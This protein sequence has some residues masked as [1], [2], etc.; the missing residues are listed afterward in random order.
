[1]NVELE[2]IVRE[3]QLLSKRFES[4]RQEL[5][6]RWRELSMERSSQAR[7]WDLT[8]PHPDELEAGFLAQRKTIQLIM[9]E[10]TDWTVRFNLAGRPLM[11][12]LTPHSE[13]DTETKVSDVE[14]VR[15]LYQHFEAELPLL[16]RIVGRLESAVAVLGSFNS[17][18]DSR[19]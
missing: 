11:D 3:T 13:S 5:T 9:E 18:P 16:E 17:A 10:F 2:E 1:V 6:Q 7:S 15:E 8:R 12:S 19:R 14:R 4:R